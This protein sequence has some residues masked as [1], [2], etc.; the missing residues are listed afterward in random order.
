[1]F[2]VAFTVTWSHVLRTAPSGHASD[3]RTAPPVPAPGRSST[4]VG[5]GPAAQ[6][7]GSAPLPTRNTRSARPTVAAPRR[8]IITPVMPR[9]N[10]VTFAAVAVCPRSSAAL[11]GATAASSAAFS[12]ALP[13]SNALSL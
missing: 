11:S 9:V 3:T 12:A 10:E 7:A 13:S 1:V 8:S 6:V 4:A 2:A 5:A